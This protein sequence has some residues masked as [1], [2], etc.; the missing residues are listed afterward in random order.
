MSCKPLLHLVVLAVGTFD[1]ES[2][3]VG[4]GYLTGIPGAG[5]VRSHLGAGLERNG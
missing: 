1:E 3:I 5:G 4:P 2:A